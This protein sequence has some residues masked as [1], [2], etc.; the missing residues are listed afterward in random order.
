MGRVL[1]FAILIG[2]V[3]W[4]LFAR[5][6][7]TGGAKGGRQRGAPPDAQEMVACARCGVHLPRG[8][9]VAEGAATYCCDEHRRLGPRPS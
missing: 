2:L 3:A 5:I 4:W 6:G 1:F 9:A 7:R 8:D